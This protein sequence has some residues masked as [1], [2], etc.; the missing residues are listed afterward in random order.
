M[1]AMLDPTREPGSEDELTAELAVSCGKPVILA[2]NKI[3]TASAEDIARSLAFYRQ[4]LPDAPVRDCR[5]ER[6][7]GTPASTGED[8]APEAPFPH[9]DDDITTPRAGH[10][11]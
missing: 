2:I 4:H 10:R 3:D 1:V 5:P 7:C 11:G 9:G 8:D 6:V